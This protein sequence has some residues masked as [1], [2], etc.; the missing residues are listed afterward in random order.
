MLCLT[1][2][3][4]DDSV[5]FPVPAGESRIGAGLDNDFVVPFPGVSRLHAR[6]TIEDGSVVIRDAGSRNGIHVSGQRVLEVRLK[7]G[8]PFQIGH[9]VVILDE[10]PTSD[11]EVGLMLTPS[12]KSS[13]EDHRKTGAGLGS[14]FSSPA[15][16]IRLIREMETR[17]GESL[18]P[19]LQE[20]LVQLRAVLAAEAVVLAAF[21]GEEIAV[22]GSTGLLPPY[23]AF[24]GLGS[25]DAFEA[26]VFE[27]EGGTRLAAEWK[28]DDPNALVAFLGVPHVAVPSWQRELI[29]YVASRIA[30]SAA[31]PGPQRSAPA[32]HGELTIPDGMV[33]GESAAMRRL[34]DQIRA[35]VRSRMD[36][37]LTGETGTGKEFLARLIHAS[38]LYAKGPFVAI[39]CAAI[40]AHL[41]ESQL[42][43]I[44]KRVATGVDPN[45]G[46]LA[47]AE[48]GV[49]FLD[50]I[51]ELAESLQAKLL[52]FLQE[53]EIHPIGASEPRKIDVLVVS[54]SNRDLEEAVRKGTFRA[55]LFYRLR[56][57]H[58]EVP[59]LRE[60]KED[61]PGLVLAIASRAAEDA[62]KRISGVSR[63]AL[64]RLMAYDWP[65][66]V[67]ELQS[68]VRR[69]VLVCSGGRLLSSEHFSIR[70][71][72][73]G[74]P[75]EKAAA[76]PEPRDPQPQAAVPPPVAPESLG[77]FRTLADRAEEMERAAIE[78]ALR[79]S[80]GNKSAAA[81]MLG[82]TRAG[83]AMKIRRLTDS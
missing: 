62:G 39:N 40:P 76:P 15:A 27:A 43:G 79:Q 33:V 9:A 29:A 65:G 31:A 45:P 49:I 69:A 56:G 42:F 20:I 54:S 16:G 74:L 38:G 35:T 78:D 18:L 23:E 37:L 77:A 73:G 71:V 83:L 75:A 61:I 70:K 57:L 24:S 81:R 2:R 26:S 28:H 64:D 30:G 14:G 47:Q 25:R 59:P 6:V 68:E 3:Y 1:A 67:R 12:P 21:P 46:L 11:F 66:N 82:I 52:R 55:D 5:R 63:K 80:H 32:P 7:R 36:V 4:R 13:R 60:R 41:L 53:R 10:A 51:G 19:R 34:L 17:A 58:F 44:H 8:E 48:G 72:P 22:R 50:E